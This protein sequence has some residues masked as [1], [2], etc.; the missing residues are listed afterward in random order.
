MDSQTPRTVFASERGA[1][2][3]ALA[4]VCVVA[5]LE[6]ALGARPVLAELLLA[7]PL[8]AAFGASARQASAVAVLALV[9]SIALGWASDAFG[10]AE[11][12]ASVIAVG[13]GGLLSVAVART[14]PF[15]M[16]RSTSSAIASA[17]NFLA[18]CP[19][20]TR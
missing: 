4:A 20:S 10:S 14:R 6:A 5:A 7:G 19:T 1:F 2:L 11:H 9:A 8:I 16:H 3:L 17:R 13:V 15:R 18:C 12:V